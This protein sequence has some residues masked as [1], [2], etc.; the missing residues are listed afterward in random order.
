[1]KQEEFI[2]KVSSDD[3]IVEEN[4]EGTLLNVYFYE[5]RW[6]FLLNLI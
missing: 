6:R 1:M 5:N 3:C 4:I 2:K